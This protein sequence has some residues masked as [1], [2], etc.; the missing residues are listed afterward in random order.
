LFWWQCHEA[1]AVIKMP[2]TAEVYAFRKIAQDWSIFL[3]RP[4]EE[5][6]LQCYETALMFPYRIQMQRVFL[7]CPSTKPVASS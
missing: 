3:E 1:A 4:L 6:W 2:Y 5:P 7:D